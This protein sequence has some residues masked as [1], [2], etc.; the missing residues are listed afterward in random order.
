MANLRISSMLLLIMSLTACT[1]VEPWQKQRLAQDDM[2]LD[3]HDVNE[4][5]MDHFYFS[6]EASSG[7]STQSGGGCG[8]N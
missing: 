3:T 8:C 5:M 4:T 2:R 7:G 1:H 6:R